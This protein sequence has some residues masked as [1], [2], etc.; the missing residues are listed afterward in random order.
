M[1]RLLLYLS[2]FIA[3]LFASSCDITI[4]YYMIDS[5]PHSYHTNQST[6]PAGGGEFEGKDFGRPC[7][8]TNNQF[9]E[10]KVAWTGMQEKQ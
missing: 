7:N 5:V 2:A 9:G 4:G 8:D 3:M 1:R 10:W 6:I